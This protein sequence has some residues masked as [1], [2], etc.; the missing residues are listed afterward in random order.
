VKVPAPSVHETLHE[1]LTK[2]YDLYSWWGAT[3]SRMQ[4]Y[5][6][7]WNRQLSQEMKSAFQLRSKTVIHVGEVAYSDDKD[8]VSAA[9]NQVFKIE[10]LFRP[11]EL[12]CTETARVVAAPLFPD[13]SLHPKTRKEILLPGL[14]TPTMTWVLAKDA[15]AKYDLA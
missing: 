2:L 14:D 10:K 3:Q 4:L 11:G 7:E 6:A 15:R 1:T 8:P 12:V 5:S 13:L 9:V